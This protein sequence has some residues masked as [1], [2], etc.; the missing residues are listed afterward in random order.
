MPHKSDIVLSLTKNNYNYVIITAMNETIIYSNNLNPSEF[1]RSLARSG[2]PCFNIRILNTMGL[3]DEINERTGNISSQSFLSGEEF[4]FKVMDIILSSPFKDKFVSYQD[5]SHLANSLK[6][7][8]LL[9]DNDTDFKNKV[10]DYTNNDN[11]KIIQYVLDKLDSQQ[12]DYVSY[13]RSTIKNITGLKLNVIYFKEEHI[14]Y[15]EK[16]LLNKLNAKEISI[17][18]YLQAP[19]SNSEIELLTYYGEEAEVEGT[20]TKIYQDKLNL[21]ETLLVLTKKDKYLN[22][23]YQFSKKNDIPMT[24]STGVNVTLSNPYK[25][26]KTLN[27]LMLV[28]QFDVNGYRKLFKIEAFDLKNEYLPEI[29]GRMKI[30]FDK[31][32]NKEKLDN[33]L[34]NKHC[35]FLLVELLGIRD[36]NNKNLLNETK[37]ALINII[38]DLSSG[39]AEFIK[40]HTVIKDNDIDVPSLEVVTSTL[41]KSEAIKDEKIRLSYLENLDNKY[42]NVS[43]SKPGHL[44]IVTLNE[45][46]SY[47][48]K[49]AFIL[50]LSASNFPGKRREDYL[51]SDEELLAINKDAITSRKRIELKNQLF[52]DVI[53]YIAPKLCLSYSYYDLVDVKEVNPSSKLYSFLTKKDKDFLTQLKNKNDFFKGEIK[54]NRLLGRAYLDNKRINPLDPV[55]LPVTNDSLV[56][57][58]KFSPS[59]IEVFLNCPRRFYAS[60][61]LKIDQVNDY[62]RYSVFEANHFG[63]LLHKLMEDYK[64]SDQE[65]DEKIDELF[66]A[67][68]ALNYPLVEIEDDH[69]EFIK[70]AHHGRKFL[71][72]FD[73]IV[74]FEQWVNGSYDKLNLLGRYDC[75][76]KKDNELVLIDFKTDREV[77]RDEDDDESI[78]QMLLYL[79]M[80]NKAD[81][82][83]KKGT[84]FYLRNGSKTNV[85]YLASKEAIIEGFLFRFKTALETRTFNVEKERNCSFCPIR[86]VCDKRK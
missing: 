32:K 42:V 3:C 35:D 84:Y 9:L 15:L 1:L 71:S 23:L 62:D 67:Y 24:F 60:R 85:R 38:N 7:V 66:N 10:K 76:A 55:Q 48:R 37:E 43:G 75:L 40:R 36:K 28:H 22:Y 26:Y 68:L 83:I 44:H 12:L 30:S 58:K 79:Y 73:E 16:E 33:L 39:M 27:D 41:I 52:D 59:D 2:K 5:I 45:A 47:L 78:A 54:S 25:L 64:L 63:T 80:M 56:G 49:N 61:I 82:N 20:L 57:F 81:K 4:T 21:D 14:S 6:N 51:I 34:N 31:D 13:L 69:K 86:D 70:A 19:K 72:S 46:R 50:G 18:E 65:F 74:N 17:L 77:N 11:I 29:L 53:S 8:R